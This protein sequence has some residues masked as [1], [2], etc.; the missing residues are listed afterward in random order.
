MFVLRGGVCNN[1]P[2]LL[3]PI[4]TLHFVFLSFTVIL[5]SAPP[6]LLRTPSAV[7][8]LFSLVS[9]L[10]SLIHSCVCF[11][12]TRKRPPVLQEPVPASRTPQVCLGRF[13]GYSVLALVSVLSAT[14][15]SVSISIV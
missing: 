12:N 8:T 13:T 7:V 9:S 2:L 5:Y 4:S 11:G 1:A 15:V 10:A 3:C 6:T 14:A